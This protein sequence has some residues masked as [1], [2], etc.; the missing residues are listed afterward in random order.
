M[1][2]LRRSRRKLRMNHGP[3]VSINAGNDSRRTQSVG[4]PQPL[5]IPNVRLLGSHM[6]ASQSDQ[7]RSTSESLDGHGTLRKTTGLPNPTDRP[8]AIIRICDNTWHHPFTA[9][10]CSVPQSLVEPEEQI[11]LDGLSESTWCKRIDNAMLPEGATAMAEVI[12]LSL[13]LACGESRL[14][15]RT[16][17]F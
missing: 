9:F 12:T 13:L 7:R 14:G 16:P 2:A 8:V 15:N 1:S 6:G 10:E 5:Q 17:A 3:T 4:S 11:Q